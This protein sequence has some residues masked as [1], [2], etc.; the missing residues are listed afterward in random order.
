MKH[1]LFLL[2][3]SSWLLAGGILPLTPLTAQVE[4]NVSPD[5]IRKSSQKI[6]DSDQFKHLK[7]Y[8]NPFDL[9][10][11]LDE[12]ET[13]SKSSSSR[14]SSSSRRA[15][16]GWFDWLPSFNFG[17]MGAAFGMLF[18][19]LFWGLLVGVALVL[20]YFIGK[21]IVAYERRGQATTEVLAD[22]TDQQI[23]VA[24]GETAVNQY[25]AR[26]RELAARGEYAQ[27]IMLLV[28]GAMSDIERRNQIKFRR[29][30]TSYDY[31][32]AV[33]GEP[34]RHQA[35]QQILRVYEPIGFGRRPATAD[36]FETS[37]NQFEAQF[38]AA[39]SPSDS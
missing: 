4:K 22:Q 25:W 33:R 14:S 31:L 39:N 1:F 15:S 3:T 37:L 35:L 19:L 27:A 26:A 29:G 21:A 24:P 7:S 2:F 30:L 17:S 9:D 23:I 13:K 36:N 34:P 12:L 16:S 28:Q 20:I 11:L 10:N 5:S 38:L 6:L 18:Q 32:R 8:K